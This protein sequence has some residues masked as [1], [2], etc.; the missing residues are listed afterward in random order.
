MVIPTDLFHPQVVFK[1][2]DVDDEVLHS[3]VTL[4]E[5]TKLPEH[6]YPVPP[7]TAIV[8]SWISYNG[9]VRS[10]DNMERLRS[11]DNQ[12]VNLHSHN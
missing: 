8:S 3:L 11:I 9:S 10:P 2:A 5:R 6:E 4:D 7:P 12:S 1:R